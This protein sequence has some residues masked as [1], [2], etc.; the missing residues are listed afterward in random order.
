MEAEQEDKDKI[1]GCMSYQ[2]LKNS[3]GQ[4]GA[5]TFDGMRI[6]VQKQVNLNTVV[7]HFYW[8]GS[9]A[10]PQPLYQYRL[11]LPFDDKSINVATNM[12]FTM[13]EGEGNLTLTDNISLNGTFG[14]NPN[15]NS[16]SLTCNITDSVS[17]TTMAYA[18]SAEGLSYSVSYVQAMTK[19]FSMGGS[20]TYAGGK[21]KPSFGGIYN[22]EENIFGAT[23]GAG[24]SKIDGIKS[25]YDIILSINHECTQYL[26][27]V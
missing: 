11:I 16:T 21:V 8:V 6:I 5:N 4:C 24:V 18:D 22:G 25:K 20:G 7:S 26:P 2:D 10:M 14:I 12:D 13:M 17:N 19:A 9:Q 1:K 15:G 23:Y 3:L 27:C